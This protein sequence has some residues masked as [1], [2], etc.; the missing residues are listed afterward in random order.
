MDRRTSPD[1]VPAFGPLLARAYARH[2]TEHSALLVRQFDEIARR[3]RIAGSSLCDIACGEGTF[4]VGMAKKGWTVT[5]VDRSQAMLD[6]AQ[7]RARKQRAKLAV[8]REDM[9]AF[10]LPEPVDLV[11]CWYNSLNYL[12]TED[13]LA[14]TFRAV[15]GALGERGWFLF[16]VYTLHGLETEWAD[17]P[18]IAVDAED[19]FVVSRTRYEPRS[20]RAEVT[21][22][23]FLRGDPPGDTA[24]YVRFEERHHHQ[25][26]P[27]ET[28]GKLLDE[29]GF[30][31]RGH[32]TMPGVAAPT[33][34][35]RRVYGAARKR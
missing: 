16:D 26:Y 15:S 28:V 19:C 8:L 20:H 13:D 12:L 33:R 35:A 14:G 1:G 10:A 7:E 25:G 6:I 32:F 4:A 2:W 29:T 22:T 9:R 11:T 23:G 5:G 17:R 21:F 34:W 31:V 24:Q 18:W 3:F 30:E 27:W